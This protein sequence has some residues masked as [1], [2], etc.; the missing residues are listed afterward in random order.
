MNRPLT[1][2]FVC[3]FLSACAEESSVD[4]A[5]QIS[6]IPSLRAEFEEFLSKDHYSNTRHENVY[7]IA[8]SEG[9]LST[10]LDL[11]ADFYEFLDYSVSGKVIFTR[12]NV[13]YCCNLRGEL[14]EYLELFYG[15]QILQELADE[16]SR[17]I[18]ERLDDFIC[19]E[20]RVAVEVD[21]GSISISVIG[22]TSEAKQ[23]QFSMFIG[24]LPSDYPYTVAKLANVKYDSGPLIA[25]YL[26]ANVS[27]TFRK[28]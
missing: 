28:Q 3:L 5:V 2:L 10:A 8:V 12:D 16:Y 20:C 14:L 6:V 7:H 9:R 1:T 26:D 17:I 4:Q 19:E 24:V 11:V 25:D 15:N 13:V 22:D 21:N 23:K 18:F 27:V